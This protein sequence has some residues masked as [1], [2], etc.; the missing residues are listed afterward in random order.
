MK[1]RNLVLLAA[2]A[3]LLI[4]SCKLLTSETAR[5][6]RTLRAAVRT[7]EK[8]GRES[9]ITEAVA[10]QRAAECFVD[11]PEIEIRGVRHAVG[12]RDEIRYGVLY[13]RAQVTTAAI[14]LSDIT[15]HFPRED[16]AEAELTARIRIT[17]AGDPAD[18]IQEF[19]VSLVRAADG[20]SWRI[21]RM[22]TVDAIQWP[23]I[24]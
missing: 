6:R 10:A 7:L 16:R 24:N 22:A 11:E 20:R 15:V 1:I 5:V 9:P 8:Q 4:G 12:T 21:S 23:G 2:T 19:A 14:T 17:A 13:A 18:W 3:L